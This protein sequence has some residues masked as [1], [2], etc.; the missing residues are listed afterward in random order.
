M[1]LACEVFHERVRRRFMPTERRNDAGA[2]ACEVAA[3]RR[4]ESAGRAGDHGHAVEERTIA[5]DQV[6]SQCDA[7]V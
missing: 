2:C 7:T 6:I 5:I 3:N 1:A 4:A